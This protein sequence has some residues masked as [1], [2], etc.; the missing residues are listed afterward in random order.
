M[1]A[2][3]G[4]CG[5]ARWRGCRAVCLVSLGGVSHL[6]AHSISSQV[7][8]RILGFA[9]HVGGNGACLVEGLVH[10]V[11]VFEEERSQDAV[12]DLDRAVVAAGNHAV[13]QEPALAEGVEGYPEEEDIAE[14]LEDREGA[15]HHPVCQPLGI[16]VFQIGFNSLHRCISRVDEADEIAQEVGSISDH[17]VEGQE[18]CQTKNEI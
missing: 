16:V 18:D 1:A 13:Y 7:S 8:A 4:W 15:V 3:L 17:Q 6:L 11:L 2:V 14:E 5:V 10:L 12:V 9:D